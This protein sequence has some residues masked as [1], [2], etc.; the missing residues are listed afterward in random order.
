MN[1][2]LSRRKFLIACAR[3]GLIASSPVGGFSASARAQSDDAKTISL[4]VVKRTIEVKGKSAS[5]YGLVQ[6]DGTRGIYSEVNQHFRVNVQNK[7]NEK[8]AIHWHGLHPPNNEDGVPGITQPF[9][10][11]DSSVL[12][13]FP[14]KPAGTHWIHSHA[15]FQEAQL[16]SAPLIVRDPKESRADEQ[17]IVVIINDFSFKEPEEIYADLLKRSASQST[18]MS[19]FMPGMSMDMSDMKAMKTSM[20][21]MGGMQMQMNGVGGMQMGVTGVG[22]MRMSAGTS[23]K[24]ESATPVAAAAGAPTMSMDANDVDYDAYLMND[25]D[26]SDPQIVSVEKSGRV[27]LRIINASSGTNYFIGLGQLEGEAIA[28]DGMPVVPVRGRLFPL[29]VA[30]RIDIRVA[31]PAE[32]SF[33]LFALREGAPER[34]GIYLA[35]PGAQV[36]KIEG[37]SQRAHQLLT[38][39]FERQLM[40]ISPLSTR[41]VD[42]TH[43]LRLTGNMT[44]YVWSINDQVFDLNR[45]PQIL[46]KL[47]QRVAFKFVNETGMSHPMHLHGHSFQV[48]EIN[49]ASIAGAVRDSLLVPPRESITVAFDADNPGLWFVHCHISWHLKAGMAATVQYEA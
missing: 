8:T 32:G 19:M 49:G 22:V 36:M 26:L 9:I 3:T 6:P 24:T 12:Y 18:R 20:P 5:V 40:A 21:D 28:V 11:P 41:P 44:K 48:V 25:R 23:S 38:S 33:P 14:L 13:D 10:Q 37:N 17:E 16:M 27:R 15:G 30:Q 35:T 39:E 29:A 47:G 4:K 43:V 2:E 31:L 7:V 1:N 42:S 46:V 45:K 34:T